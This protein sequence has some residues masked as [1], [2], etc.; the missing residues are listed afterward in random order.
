MINGKDYR[1]FKLPKKSGGFRMIHAPS[2]NLKMIQR[3]MLPD[4]VS[5]FR[6]TEKHLGLGR[7]AHGFIKGRNAVTGAKQHIGYAVTL[8][9]DISNFFDNV[10]IDMVRKAFTVS[11]H[12]VGIAVEEHCFV[13]GNLIQGFVTSPI[14]ATIAILPVLRNIKQRITKYDARLTMYADDVQISTNSTSYDA[15]N[16]LQSIVTEEFGY[17]G[18]EINRKKTRSRFAKYGYRKI[19]GVNVGDDHVRA[20]R[21][22][23]RKIR[24]AEHQENGRSLGGLRNW[25][26]CPIP[27]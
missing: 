2:T 3:E 27:K 8:Q 22:V 19:L 26:S 6:K 9:M 21:K 11:G 5:V 1:V 23:M 4:L 17:L 18:L 15:L 10:T 7:I 13:R 25:A 14:L 20:T 24:A 12:S 16:D